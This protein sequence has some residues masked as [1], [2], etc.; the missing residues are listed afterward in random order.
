MNSK[1]IIIVVLL[2]MLTSCANDKQS[3]LEVIACV[4]VFTYSECVKTIIDNNCII[5]HHS[6]ANAL[7]PFPLETYD[8]V[9]E[10]VEDGNLLARIQLPDG[11][12]G[13]MPQVGKMSQ[14]EIDAILVWVAEGFIE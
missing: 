7:G 14:T 1:N 10:K 2:L 4:D 9:K 5:C 3:D 13:I 11:A 8:Q 12:N 6:G